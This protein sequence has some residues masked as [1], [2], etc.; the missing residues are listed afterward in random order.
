MKIKIP[1]L[2]YKTDQNKH[3]LLN[4]EVNMIYNRMKTFKSYDF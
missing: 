3:T 2:L 4:I 1:V